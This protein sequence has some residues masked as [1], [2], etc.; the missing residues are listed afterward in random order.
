[1]PFSPAGMTPLVKPASGVAAFILT[2]SSR[3][4]ISSSGKITAVTV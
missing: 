1:M 2:P 4:P 3:Q